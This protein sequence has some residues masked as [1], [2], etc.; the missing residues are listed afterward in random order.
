MEENVYKLIVRRF[1]SIFYPPAEYAKITLTQRSGKE[2]FVTSGKFLISKGYMEIAGVK[3][4]S[5]IQLGKLLSK[6][7]KGEEYQTQYAISNG[8]TTPP[9]KYTSGSIVLAM[10]N[11]GQLIED[12]TLRDQIKSSGIGTSATR[13]ETI[14][15]LI[16]LGYLSLDKKFF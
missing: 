5:D 4:G 1:L 13:G 9:K 8:Q 14:K 10:E 11:A 7:K 15:K 2:T 6:I 16:R 3:K 12:E